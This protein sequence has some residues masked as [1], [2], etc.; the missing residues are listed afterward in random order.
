MVD[1]QQVLSVGGG[2]AGLGQQL[3]KDPEEK[4]KPGHLRLF[5][6]FDEMGAEQIVIAGSRISFAKFDGG[7]C[8]LT[9]GATDSDDY[10]LLAGAV[11]LRRQDG[12]GKRVEAGSSEAREAIAHVRPSLYEV[13]A[14]TPV[15][16]FKIPNVV[17]GVLRQEAPQK[18]T[19]IDDD[20]SLD[21]T[22]TRQ[23]LHEFQK[24]LNSNRVVLHSL[25]E[26]VL[27]LSDEIE[28]TPDDL[29]KLAAIVQCDP[30]L[31]IK[32][33]KIA[34]SPVF[35]GSMEIADCTRALSRL[36]PSMVSELVFCFSMKDVFKTDSEQVKRRIERAWRASIN[37][38]AL[39]VAFSRYTPQLSKD[40]LALAGLLHNVGVLPI[41]NYVSHSPVHLL[42]PQLID[43][44]VDRMQARAGAMILRAWKLGE[45]LA[46]V[47]ETA[48]DWLHDSGPELVYGD[49]VNLALYH[50][51]LAEKSRRKLPPIEE[52]PA[53]RKIVE[54]GLNPELSMTIIHDAQAMAG[55]AIQLLS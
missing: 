4:F 36:G 25:S 18:D 20:M 5:S 23:F 15:T 26:V 16:V 31:T 41:F 35:R 2:L 11:E 13:L 44:A 9:F 53:A 39:S 42:K 33:L 1:K 10:Y 32:L 24:E 8:L 27:K 43:R 29:K 37:V 47:V 7:E 14:L 6:P 49:I 17:V 54:G 28:R 38:A 3:A 50:H 51:L 46:K 48:G 22:H 52:M 45:D 30:A 34:N 12:G 40:R 19:Q 21:V 55:P